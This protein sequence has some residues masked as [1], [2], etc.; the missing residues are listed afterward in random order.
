MLTEIEIRNLKPKEKPYKVFD[1]GGLYLMV[2]PKGHKA[3]NMKYRMDG[4]EHRIPFGTYP[5]ITLKEAR[6]KR[7]EARRQIYEG[8]NP[9]AKQKQ[10]KRLAA[11]NAANTFRTIAIE[12]HELNKS[13]WKERHAQVLMRRMEIHLFPV[14]GDLPIKDIRALEILSALRKVEKN[15]TT[16]LAHRLLQAC[17]LVF[18]F[19]II[20]ERAES[21]PA[22]DLQ[23]ALRPH[24]EKH[25]PTL[26]EKELPEFLEALETVDTTVQNKL[27]IKLLLHTM[28]RQG[29]L[30]RSK[31]ENIDW[32]AKEWH[33]PAENTK[34][35]D[36]HVVPLADQTIALLKELHALKGWSKYLFPSQARQKNPIMSENT[37]NTVIKRM[38]YEGKIVGHGFRALAST[39]LN[40]HNFKPD[41]IERQLAHKERNKIRA[42][43]HRSEY[44]PAR[45]EM[46]QWWADYL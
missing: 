4:K 39:I 20:T 18:R 34:M 14:I 21:N 40:E 30:R 16:H 6:M 19:A 29:E 1:S 35:N 31:W 10:E 13:K 22:N 41:V 3:W 37:I 9:A 5:L 23:G 36:A 27:A 7:D 45:R 33:I 12:W 8:I 2:S 38:G 32:E 24:K 28:L 46:M 25:Y 15:D 26:K 42:A 17:K 43:Y 11:F 44:L